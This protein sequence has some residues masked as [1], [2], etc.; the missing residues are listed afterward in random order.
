MASQESTSAS[1]K[2]H[3]RLANV[4]EQNIHIIVNNRE[5]VAS[6]RTTEDKVAD[7]V[8]RFS[9]RMKFVYLHVVWFGAWMLLN[10]GVFGSEP[11]DPFPF[12]LL[13]MIVSLEAIFI[14][15]FVL[16]SQ[17]RFSAEAERRADLHL[18]IG[19]LTEHELTRALKMLDAIQTKLGIEDET[20]ADLHELEEDVH[21]EDILNEIKLVQERIGGD[22]K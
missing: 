5:A 18:H 3:S 14:S 2:H 16:I 1:K 13:T 22:L 7:S 9:G 11:F 15:A 6:Q 21:P 8:T 12:G 4:I 10:S 20:V 17:E 19:L